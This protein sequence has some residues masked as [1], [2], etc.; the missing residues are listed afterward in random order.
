M[1]KFNENKAGA[2]MEQNFMGEEAY[3][4][5]DKEALTSMVMTTFLTDAYYVSENQLTQNI[6]ELAQKCGYEFTAKLA[7]YART[8]GNLRSVSHLL[9]ALVCKDS[10]HPAWL[11]SFYEHIVLRPDDMS[12][13]LACYGKLNGSSTGKLRKIPNAMKRGFSTVLSNLSPYQIDKYKM[14]GKSLSLVDIV[15][16]IHPTPTDKNR[17]AYR[18]LMH[19]ESLDGTYDSKILEKE[20]SATGQNASNE[21]EL[22]LA[23]HDAIKSVLEKGMPIMN[24]LRNL[25]NIMLYAPDL[26]DEAINQLTNHDKIVNSRLLPFRFMSAYDVIGKLEISDYAANEESGTKVAFES[27][28]AN[29]SYSHLDTLK[30]KVQKALETAMSIACENVPELEGNC[31]ILIDHSGSVRGD[32]GG[33]SK[34]SPWSSVN[35]AHIGNLFGSIVAFKQKDVY[36]GMFGDRLISPAMDRSIGLLEFNKRTYGEGDKCGGATENGLYTFLKN[37]IEEKKHI[38]NFIVFSD[39]EIGDGG[40]GG[41][42]CTSTSRVKFKDLFKEFRKINPNC[43]T[44]CCNIRAQS[45]TSVFNPNLKILNVSGWS[46]NIFDVIS[47]Y[48]VGHLK[49]MVEDIEKM[50]L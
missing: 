18:R 2:P 16:L 1:S 5:S 3:V 15:N 43:L 37:V 40:E 49:S 23:K 35:T 13:I 41:W 4:L 31:A 8:K 7:L 39:M 12:E 21:Q 27:D 28:L 38:D 44:V 6:V 50:A 17:E 47:M 34:V 45:G 11:K 20:M 46:N 9:A 25:R 32:W 30:S 10:T 42:D 22:V 36:I 29:M 24:L 48:K 33:D 19:G 26:I 14:K